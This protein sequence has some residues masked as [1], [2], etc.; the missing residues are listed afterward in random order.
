MKI[1][2]QLTMNDLR[3]SFMSRLIRL[4]IGAL[5]IAIPMIQGGI[6]DITAVLPLLAIYPIIT[7]ILGFGLIELLVFCNQR[8][9]ERPPQQVK[10][11]CTGLFIAGIGLIAFV[12]V[13]DV[14]PA[15]LALVAIYPILMAIT[16]T[17]LIGK[18]LL[19]RRILQVM[20]KPTAKIVY[21]QSPKTPEQENISKLHNPK[22][23]A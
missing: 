11:A 18:S 4:A 17:D 14:A 10:V 16:G 9:T 19:T 1:Y 7:G 23:A 6:L 20:N 3:L 22:Q 12:M 5:F 15:W 21:A 13:S 2:T 8:R